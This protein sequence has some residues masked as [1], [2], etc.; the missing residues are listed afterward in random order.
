MK[1]TFFKSQYFWLIIV[2]ITYCQVVISKEESNS[3][4]KVILNKEII[5]NKISSKEMSQESKT[6]TKETIK[7]NA[8]FKSNSKTT[9]KNK[10]ENTKANTK[11]MNSKEGIKSN[12]ALKSSVK[13]SSKSSVEPDIIHGN[14]TFVLSYKNNTPNP[15]TENNLHLKSSINSLNRING[16]ATQNLTAD[17]IGYTEIPLMLNNQSPNVMIPNSNSYQIHQ[18]PK[19][20]NNFEIP[21]IR[22]SNMSQINQIPLQNLNTLDMFHNSINVNEHEHE[23]LNSFKNFPFNENQDTFNNHANID[24]SHSK[25][26]K[27]KISEKDYN[28]EEELDNINYMIKKGLIDEAK[29]YANSLNYDFGNKMNLH[30]SPKL[31]K[32]IEELD[33]LFNNNEKLDNDFNNTKLKDFIHSLKESHNNNSKNHISSELNDHSF[34]KDTNTNAK[35][36]SDIEKNN[37]SLNHINYESILKRIKSIPDKNLGKDELIKLKTDLIKELKL[38]QDNSKSES[39]D[40]D[41]DDEIENIKEFPENKKS[42]NEISNKQNDDEINEQS[43]QK[44]LT[45][46]EMINDIL[47]W[48]N[49]NRIRFSEKVTVDENNLKLV[50][51]KHLNKNEKIIRVN[52]NM[53]IHEEKDELKSLCKELK[54]IKQLVENYSKICISLFLIKSLSGYNSNNSEYY[55]YANLLITNG[56]KENYPSFINNKVLKEMKHHSKFFEIVSNRKNLFK[57]EFELISHIAIF[58]DDKNFNLENYMLARLNVI[59]RVFEIEKKLVLSPSKLFR[60]FRNDKISTSEY[61]ESN[62]KSTSNDSLEKLVVLAPLI[63][64]VNHSDQNRA[65][66][67]I[68]MNDHELVLYNNREIS[69]D[70]EVLLNYG[71]Y[72][73]YHL[74]LYFGIILESNNIPIEYTL[75]VKNKEIL[76]NSSTSFNELLG[77]FNHSRKLRNDSSDIKHHILNNFNKEVEKPHNS[78]HSLKEIMSNIAKLNETLNNKIK[79]LEKITDVSKNKKSKKLEMNTNMNSNISSILNEE[80]QLLHSF[81]NLSNCIFKTLKK[82]H[83]RMQKCKEMKKSKLNLEKVGETFFESIKS[84]KELNSNEINK[85]SISAVAKNQKNIKVVK[86]EKLTN[87]KLLRSLEEL[88]S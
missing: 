1:F 30:E 44:E 49:K 37:V 53:L 2:L 17:K 19:F 21:E 59:N 40:D 32:E 45:K 72:S 14:D 64:I 22:R 52:K 48:G 24:P 82:R 39:D 70:N 62:S 78:N 80:Q 84:L 5:Q 12:E 8:E 74:F 63:E 69:K 57:E 23:H 88:L 13:N 56:S 20:Q 26:E 79:L 47:T 3:K 71:N 41:S 16:S 6:Y 51:N 65:N 83:N 61:N 31:S 54:N 35:S 86:K 29:K 18:I 66:S 9:I 73:N 60:K 38:L 11:E 42:N 55:E 87:D 68:K 75:K 46:N 58:K 7:S 77:L 81:Y 43:N 4:A 76:L 85:N 67:K 25:L 27:D 15:K 50:A 36:K 28:I 34:N 10:T 33:K